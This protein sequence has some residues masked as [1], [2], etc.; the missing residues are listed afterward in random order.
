MLRYEFQGSRLRAQ[1]RDKGFSREAL[2]L[3]AG[4]SYQAISQY[5][6]GRVTPPADIVGA[7]ASV[8]GCS[9]DAFYAN[10]Q[11]EVA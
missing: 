10:S 5:E 11:A 6:R 2:G 8:L 7:L 9:P 1:R 3:A 4:R